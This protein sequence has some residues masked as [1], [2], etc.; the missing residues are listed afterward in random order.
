MGT[1]SLAT[2]NVEGQSVAALLDTGA[3]VSTMKQ[4]VVTQLG[5]SLDPVDQILRVECANGQPLP[6]L[7]CV[8]ANVSLIDTVVKP[9]LFLVVPD[10]AH[11][12]SVPVLLGTNNLEQ[13]LPSTPGDLP[14]PLQMVVNCFIA[15][16]RHLQKNGGAIAQLSCERLTR[17]NPGSMVSVPVSVKRDFDFPMTHAMVERSL[18]STF[19]AD[20][21][22]S[23]T[24]YS[25]GQERS[26]EVTLT[27]NTLS[28]LTLA[29]GTVVAQLAPVTIANL[30][31]ASDPT[32]FVPQ[33]SSSLSPQVSSSLSPQV[34]SSPFPQVSSSPFPQVSSLS[35]Q[36]SSSPFPQVSSNSFCH[37]SQ[38]NSPS[39]PQLPD[40]TSAQIS[41]D[42]RDSLSQLVEEYAD[43]FSQGDFDIGHYD[44]VKHH[45]ELTDERPFKQ[46]FR[47]IPPHLLE[48]VAD[49]LRQ[50][51]ANGVIRPS[52]S[53]FS[54]PIV[55]CRKKDGSLRMCV[56]FRLLNSR[57]KKDNYCLPRIE[58]ILDS[59]KGARFFSTL[60][61]KSGYHHIEIAE[62]HKERTAFTVGPLG[63][64]EH[65][66]LAFG[67]CNSPATFQRVM[68]DCFSDVHLRD[69]FIYLD[70]LL[71]Y[72]S[73]VE[74]H[75]VKLR[76]IFDRLRECGLKLAPKKCDFLKRQISFLGF[77]VSEDGVHTDPGKIEKVLS[78]PTPTGVSDLAS[79]LGFA[80]YYRRFVKEYSRIAKPLSDLRHVHPSKWSWGPEH[81]KAFATLKRELC[82]APVLA[83]PDFTVPFELHTDAS[84]DGLG[85][86]LYQ[87][88]DGRLKVV[89][90]AS[91]KLNKAE[92]RYPAHKREFLALKW[93][94]TDKFSEYLYAA[95]HFVVKTDNNPLTYV[96]TTAKLD[97]TGH[98]WLA[99]LAA[100][101]F[102]IQYT[103]GSSMKDADGLSR[104]P[105]DPIDIATVQAA[106]HLI[107]AP[108][109]N[110]LGI[111]DDDIDASP[112][113]ILST[114]EI[115]KEQ[116][117]DSIISVWMTALR[118]GKIPRLENSPSPVK[119]GLMKR[120]FSKFFFRRG[121][122][123][124]RLPEG[125]QLV[126]PQ[127]FVSSVCEALHDDCGHQGL[128]KTMSLIRERFFWPRM[129]VDVE[130][131]VHKC[132]RCLRFKAK[133]DLA[134]LVGVKTTEPLELVCTDFLKVDSAGNGTQYILVITDHFTRFAKAIP[135]RNM[136][137]RTTAEALLTF[138]ENFGIPQRL[139]SD[140]GANFESKVIRELCQLLGVQKSRTTP[141][142]AMGNGSCERFNQT[143]I[144]MLGTLPSEKKRNWPKHIGMLVLAYN[145]TP[146]HSTGFSPFFLLFGRA[147]RLPVDNLFP[148]ESLPKTVE[149]VR[150]ALQWAWSKASEND[151][152]AKDHSKRYYDRK[153]RGGPLVAG[154]RVLVRECAFDA[155][156]KLKDK[157]SESIFVVVEKPH[158]SIPVYRVREESGGKVRTVHRNLLLPVQS[159]RDPPAP[160]QCARAPVPP[161]FEPTSVLVRKLSEDESPR[162]ESTEDDTLGEDSE[163]EE[164]EILV[165]RPDQPR[166]E[167]QTRPDHPSRISVPTPPSRISVPTPPSRI[168]VSTSPLP[169][170]AEPVTDSPSV[171]G[172]SPELR[173]PPP[174]PLPRVSLRARQSPAWQTSGEFLMSANPKVPMLLSLLEI[175]HI[176]T[177]QVT[178]ALLSLI[179]V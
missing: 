51:E 98:R 78:W 168:S 24:L 6:Y 39:N 157:W 1:P 156:H 154:D 93:S 91:R 102:E 110:S 142:H 120:N 2:L 85:A 16:K 116:N 31:T 69:L 46:R 83:Y 148:R 82:T 114:K 25:C 117:S 81:E 113:P 4:S 79:F 89:S 47:R 71:V 70:D 80:G 125:E 105:F 152:Q 174:R 167:P 111:T 97:A 162:M 158:D 3:T 147:P 15:R 76:R 87:K 66:R 123:Y 14:H 72:S 169:T 63:F 96:L 52:K 135:T 115:R 84:G 88:Q 41:S 12:Q 55:C 67:L 146:H 178:S 74:E 171:Q 106:C 122:M 22:I 44:G 124:R 163:S 175:P 65:N 141:Y 107:S 13:L 30:D 126:L 73:S 166:K 172:Q 48:E 60:D 176:D 26:L 29:P 133:P 155:P 144:R 99:A 136:S 119:H 42:E 160:P 127:K 137:A 170:T 118:T 61:L 103:P 179:L 100:Y 121:V 37:G 56:D 92:Q 112:F 151:D 64:W 95:P 45:I 161:V 138:C 57:T 49:H 153:V 134:P 54:S 101:D 17:L 143:V 28:S 59:L 32:S 18:S 23:P 108:F 132:G 94:V 34:S 140:Q 109:A 35:P 9:G 139:H 131:W 90:F 58:N 43:V 177:S 11:S 21:E 86:V 104:L 27:N 19:S 33:V 68:E 53:P 36:V 50:L 150:E 173:L 145:A 164:G 7:G 165:A 159:I 10:S 130:D 128:D 129:S 77:V 5:L 38:T 62:E 149:D 8:V 75:L 20:V 40:L